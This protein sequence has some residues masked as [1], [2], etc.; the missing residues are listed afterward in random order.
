MRRIVTT[1]LNNMFNKRSCFSIEEKSFS[2]FMKKEEEIV[3]MDV[4]KDDEDGQYCIRLSE[5]LDI[6]KFKTAFEVEDY[7]IDHFKQKREDKLSLLDLEKALKLRIS[8]KLEVEN[9]DSLSYLYQLEKF[10]QSKD[11]KFRAI[12]Y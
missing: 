2:F 6:N 5:D 12:C 8:E 9:V 11:D 1:M 4:Y 10:I 3:I 7:Y